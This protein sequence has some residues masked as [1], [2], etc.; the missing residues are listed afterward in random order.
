M[1]NVRKLSNEMETFFVEQGRD[2]TPNCEC[3]SVNLRK[4]EIEYSPM[5]P[6]LSIEQIE[7]S[8]C[9]IVF[10]SAN[11]TNNSNC[12]TCY[13]SRLVLNATRVP[14]YSNSPIP[15][16]SDFSITPTEIS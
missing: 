11:G 15:S 2:D 7:L 6:S 1:P 13:M 14:K 16:H 12:S 3:Y 8:L 10:E 4:N 9:S 5:R